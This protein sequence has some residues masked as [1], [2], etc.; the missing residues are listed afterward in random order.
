MVKLP[1]DVFAQ[2][3]VSV[4][5]SCRSYRGC[6]FRIEDHIG[7]LMAS[8]RTVGLAVPSGP[9]ALKRA[10]YGALADSGKKEAFLRITLS[11]A[12]LHISVTHRVWPREVYVKGV[13]LRT[14]TVRKSLSHALYPEAKT[15]N[16]GAQMLATLEMP[17]GIFDVVFVGV[18]GCVKECRTSNI[19]LVKEGV[20]RTPPAAAILEGVTRR[21]VLE[22]APPAGLRCEETP[23]TRHDFYNAAE[24]FLTNTSGEII[25]VREMDGRKIGAAVPGVWTRR[26]HQAFKRAVAGYLKERKRHHA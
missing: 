1:V 13:T 12:G 21:V 8:A 10:L 25:P 5:E 2:E 22:V 9:D 14:A 6:I 20:L 19:F 17:P 24:V 11:P 26:L 7:R 18:D 16:Y 3:T 15:S 23:L 4:F